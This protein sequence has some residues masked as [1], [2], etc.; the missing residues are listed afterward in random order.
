MTFPCVVIIC[1]P[2]CCS[3]LGLIESFWRYLIDL[4]R[5]NH[6]EDWIEDLFAM[7]KKVMSH[8]DDPACDYRFHVIKNLRR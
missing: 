5:A 7:A 6:L 8:Q 1:L 3:E 2:P 4:A